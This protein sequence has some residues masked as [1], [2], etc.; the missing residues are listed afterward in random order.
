[1]ANRKY[2]AAKS[3]SIRVTHIY[4]Q[5]EFKESLISFDLGT[6]IAKSAS[7]FKNKECLADKNSTKIHSRRGMSQFIFLEYFAMV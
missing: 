5:N 1:M 3:I 4:T 7:I 2:A 6:Q